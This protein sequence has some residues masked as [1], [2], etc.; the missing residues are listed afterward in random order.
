LLFRSL[1]T[2]TTCTWE[3][4]TATLLLKCRRR[5]NFLSTAFTYHLKLSTG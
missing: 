5:S 3:A 2:L 4:F 1:M